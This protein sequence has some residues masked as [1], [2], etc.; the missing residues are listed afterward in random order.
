M[1]A[2][3]IA[4]GRGFD[5]V[6]IADGGQLL[7]VLAYRATLG[8]EIS[9]KAQPSRGL[10]TDFLVAHTLRTARF[11]SHEK[12]EPNPWTSIWRSGHEI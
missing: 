4:C 5:K 10:G 9:G 7:F 12:T 6:S 3:S 2:F 1:G 11:E 8:W